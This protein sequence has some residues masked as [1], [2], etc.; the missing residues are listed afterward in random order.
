MAAARTVT[1]R[2]A[3]ARTGAV[4]WGSPPALAAR[5]VRSAAMTPAGAA[6]APRTSDAMDARTPGPTPAGLLRRIL[7]LK[8]DLL[9]PRTGPEGPRGTEETPR[10]GGGGW[11]GGDRAHR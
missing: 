6:R 5:R 4:A 3:T 2:T 7:E 11:S 8:E 1:G 9:P 10:A